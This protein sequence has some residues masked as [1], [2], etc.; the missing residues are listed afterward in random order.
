MG[1]LFLSFMNYRVNKDG[2]RMI[3]SEEMIILF[4]QKSGGNYVGLRL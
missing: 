2:L 3:S 1:K 4:I